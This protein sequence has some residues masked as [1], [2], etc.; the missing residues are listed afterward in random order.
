MTKVSWTAFSGD[1]LNRVTAKNKRRHSLIGST[2]EEVLLGFSD[3]FND[4]EPEKGAGQD[5]RS[6]SECPKYPNVKCSNYP[7]CHEFSLKIFVHQITPTLI[8]EATAAIL[9]ELGF[10]YIDSLIVSLDE[11]ITKKELDTV[12][13]QMETLKNAGRVGA[14]GMADLTVA[15]L[16]YLIDWTSICPDLMQICPLTYDA[17][18]A[19]KDSSVKKIMKIGQAKNVRITTHNDPVRTPSKLKLDLENLFDQSSQNLDSLYTARYTQRSK[20]RNIITM[21]GYY[22]NLIT[23]D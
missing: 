14:I 5:L 6:R 13:K 10:N 12:W 16:Q 1:L 3:V 22:M 8:G 11:N 19:D 23:S 7:R 15:Q 2:E 4:F 17:I 20:D 9:A 18:F 21:K